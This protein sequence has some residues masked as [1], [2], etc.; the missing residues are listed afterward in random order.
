MARAYM[1]E[2]F[3]ILIMEN[4]CY[5]GEERIEDEGTNLFMGIKPDICRHIHKK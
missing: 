4:I 2:K 3:K 1:E 5:K